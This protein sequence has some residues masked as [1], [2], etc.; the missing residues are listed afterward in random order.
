MFTELAYRVIVRIFTYLYISVPVFAAV[1][2]VNVVYVHYHTALL[3][4]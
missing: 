3:P 4:S 2:C 1:V